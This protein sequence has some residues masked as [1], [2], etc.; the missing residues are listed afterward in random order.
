M[1]KKFGALLLGLVMMLSFASSTF[2]AN[3]TNT[4]WNIQ[5]TKIGGFHVRSQGTISFD[6]PTTTVNFNGWASSVWD[7]GYCEPVEMKIYAK[8]SVTR[9]AGSSE[10]GLAYQE[11]GTKNGCNAIVVS[12]SISD[13]F[14]SWTI[15]TATVA[16]NG[17]IKIPDGDIYEQVTAVGDHGLESSS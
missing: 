14:S 15:S 17:W 13:S 2:A 3:P 5:G 8:T 7:G 16:A 4:T 10:S 11:Q 12:T 9:Y 6:L 1:K